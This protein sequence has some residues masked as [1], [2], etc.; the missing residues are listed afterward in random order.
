[1][2][3]REEREILDRLRVEVSSRRV[4]LPPV[5]HPLWPADPP[6]SGT[7]WPVVSAALERASIAAAGR[8]PFGRGWRGWVAALLAPWR[9]ASADPLGLA[10]AGVAAGLKQLEHEVARLH[11]AIAVVE[12]LQLAA[13][14]RLEDSLADHERTLTRLL[15]DAAVTPG[16]RQVS[17][18]GPEEPERE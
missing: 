9:P 12:Q 3:D 8:R 5:V 16:A 11:A 4:A 6:R 1:M 2:D 17:A 18:T 10:T 15:Q 13:T 7:D 14:R